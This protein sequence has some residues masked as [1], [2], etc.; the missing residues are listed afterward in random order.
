MYETAITLKNL[1]DNG[2]IID[3]PNLIGFYYNMIR[4]ER[5]AF[6]LDG[7]LDFSEQYLPELIKWGEKFP[8][9]S[10]IWAAIGNC[11][12]IDTKHYEKALIAYKNVL[13]GDHPY[14]FLIVDRV[15][16]AAKK[17]KADFFTL[18]FPLQ[19]TGDEMYELLTSFNQYADKTKKKKYKKKYLQQAIQFGAEGY[20]QYED[21]LIK[22]SGERRNNQ[23]HRFA[24]LCNNYANAL[25]EDASL[26]Y[27]E[28]S[29]EYLKQYSTAG[30]THLVGYKM[31]PFIENIRNASYKFFK[32]KD[33]KKSVE[34][35][36]QVLRDF[37]QALS[38][39][40][41]Q[42]FYLRLVK[43]HVRLK[44]HSEA[45]RYYH[46]AKALY[47]NVSLDE[48]EA[49][50]N[51]IFIAKIFYEYIFENKIDDESLIP[52]MQWFVEQAEFE[53]QEAK[54]VGLVAYYLG[55][56]HLNANQSDQAIIAFQHSV[57]LLQDIDDWEF[58]E[59]KC[60]LAEDALEDLGVK[61]IKKKKHNK[62]ALRRTLDAILFPFK[63]C[64]KKITIKMN[65]V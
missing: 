43:S 23:T 6:G 33:Y 20:R 19:G 22:G 26:I 4:N 15:H 46:Q 58:Y 40:D 47:E 30:E 59:E 29:A 7:Q 48:E 50:H 49:T 24:M 32:A 51:F 25:G 16:K 56:S 10:L 3:R 54:E 60:E 64:L 35:S 11:Y 53:R 57:D 14:N 28:D 45:K 17:S 52:D 1:I 36:E 9:C 2:E 63:L 27:E 61:I 65:K 31:S 39:E 13:K 55:Q 44:N 37:K 8:N 42:F 34:C 12:H 5:E 62:S 18:D 21:Y 41:T 38:I